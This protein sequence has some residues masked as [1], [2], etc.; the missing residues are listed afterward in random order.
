MVMGRWCLHAWLGAMADVRPHTYAPRPESIL[1]LP[2][3][4]D[5]LHVRPTLALISRWL[6]SVTSAVTSATAD[7][8]RSDDEG[9][10]DDHE[11]DD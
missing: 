5:S 4:Q 11:K 9:D 7:D 6:N 2:H 8:E 10:D 3:G 1:V